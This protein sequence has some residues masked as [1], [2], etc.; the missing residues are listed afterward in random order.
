ML[1]SIPSTIYSDNCKEPLKIVFLKKKRTYLL[2][3]WYI[4]FVFK[5]TIFLK[6]Y[7]GINI[8]QCGF[9][10]GDFSSF[11]KDNPVALGPFL[12]KIAFPILKFHNLFIYTTINSST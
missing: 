3:V 2:P 11:F 9:V 5:L 1:T 4:C 10:P 8:L 12:T 7:E 6:T